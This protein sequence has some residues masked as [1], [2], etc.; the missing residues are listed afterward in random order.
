MISPFDKLPLSNCPL[1]K[2]KKTAYY[3]LMYKQRP[4]VTN[5]NIDQN[6]NASL[7]LAFESHHN[8]FVFAVV[9]SSANRRQKSEQGKTHFYDFCRKS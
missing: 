6:A 8:P 7:H 5:K 4:R 1:S 2:S 3:K 9:K